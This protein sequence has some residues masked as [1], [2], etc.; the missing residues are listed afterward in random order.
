MTQ[1]K[2]INHDQTVQENW[3]KFKQNKDLPSD[4]R[5]HLAK[6]T[7]RHTQTTISSAVSLS[8]HRMEPKKG[9]DFSEIILSYQRLKERKNQDEPSL[10]NTL[11]IAEEKPTNKQLVTLKEFQK[12]FPKKITTIESGSEITLTQEEL[13][14]IVQTRHKQSDNNKVGLVQKSS[15]DVSHLIYPGKITI[16]PDIYKKGCTY[17]LNDCYYNSDGYFL[18]RVPG[19]V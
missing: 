4:L 7:H 13:T 14:K 16:P 17:K 18:Y 3:A 5:E 9:G 10:D 8:K 1:Q 11:E 19:M 6:F 2:I 15:K 12:N